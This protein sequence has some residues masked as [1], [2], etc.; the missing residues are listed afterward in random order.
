MSVRTENILP[1]THGREF[2]VDIENTEEFEEVKNH[3][4]KIDGVDNVT[5]NMES[6]PY[7][8]CI[9]TNKMVQIKT[10]QDAIS[11]KGHHAVPSEAL[12]L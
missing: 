12:S 3:L 1:H 8:I 9:Q 10:I 4:L 11:D 7:E 6:Y 2:K 5:F